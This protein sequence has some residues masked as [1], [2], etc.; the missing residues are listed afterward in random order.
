MS[1]LTTSPLTRLSWRTIGKLSYQFCRSLG[2]NDETQRCGW[3]PWSAVLLGNFGDTAMFKLNRLGNGGQSNT[4]KNHRSLFI[5][6]GI[7]ENVLS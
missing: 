5:D 7:T 6:M 2:N 1:I 3:R 4:R